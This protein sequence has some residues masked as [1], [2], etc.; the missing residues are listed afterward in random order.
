ME[1]KADYVVV[2]HRNTTEIIVDKFLKMIRENEL[3]PGDKLPPERELAQII[4][5]SRPSLRE[6]IKALQMMNVLDVRQGS[7]T[8]IKRLEPDSIVDHLDIVFKMD[9]TLR[10]D[11]Y[12][13]RI[14]LEAIIARIAVPRMSEETIRKIGRNVEESKEHVNDLKRFAQLD[15]ELHDMI[16]NAAN[17]RILNMF[18]QSINKV[19][20]A[21]RRETNKYAVIRNM[22][23]D[24]HFRIYE[25]IQ[26][27]D[28]DGT[29]RAMMQ[30]LKNI[31]KNYNKIVKGK[32]NEE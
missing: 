3:K 17:N 9:D 15:L 30:H 27:R 8:Y 29:A 32:E 28:A 10:D 4:N 7:G 13:A 26:K 20:M 16:L 23:V 6:A 24:D 22:T 31:E 12:E 11:L 14:N 21:M 5:T 18:I 2:N 1:K 19:S 25:K